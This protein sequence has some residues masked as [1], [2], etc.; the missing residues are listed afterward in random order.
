M[1]GG[2]LFSIL[3]AIAILALITSLACSESNTGPDQEDTPWQ[4]HLSRLERNLSPDATIEE[5]EKLI[6]GNHE[7]AIALYDIHREAEDSNLLFSVFSIRIAFAMVYGGAL[8]ETKTQIAETLHFTLEQARLHNAFNALDLSLAERNIPGD[9][10]KDPV[11]LYVANAFWGQAGLPFREAYLDLLA[12]NYGSGLYSLD[13]TIDP[14]AARRVINSWV[15]EKTR[16]R[17]LDLLPEGS[18]TPATIA[19]LTNAI[20]LKAPRKLH[21]EEFSTSDTAFRLLDGSDVIVPMM[22][23]VGNFGY[24]EGEYYQALEKTYR[25]DELSMVFLLPS[26]GQF[27][28]FESG[29]DPNLLADILEGLASSK[30]YVT[31]PRFSFESVFSLKETLQA[32]GMVIPFD[33]TADFTGIVAD[34]P[35]YIGD[36]YHKTFIAV[37]EKGT[38]A[39]AATAVVGMT[40]C[41]PEHEFRA[42]RPF[43]FLIRD[44]V[45]GAILFMG[46]V[47]NPV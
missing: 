37:D 1:S 13:Y 34:M 42:D 31:L 19:V 8:G 47:L 16:D 4:T 36:A 14:D 6:R 28:A 10:S 45:T 39:A 11:E 35:L 22:K 9:E 41:G 43:I 21:F 3:K 46:R 5:L 33:P 20:Y 30:I 40:F 44:R 26:P 32:M 17:I 7:F 29:L 15:A 23:Q 38:E 27:S 12:L 25:G 24:T 18:L 2:R